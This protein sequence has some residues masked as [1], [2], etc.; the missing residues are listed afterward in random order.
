MVANESRCIEMDN[1]NSI[2]QNV[3]NSFNIPEWIWKPI[4]LT[5]SSGNPNNKYVT[6]KEYSVGLFQ[7]NRIAHPEYT[8][9]ELL[10]PKVN[11][12]IAAKDFIIPALNS[13]GFDY[14]SNPDWKTA[15]SIYSGLKDPTKTSD[16]KGSDYIKSGGI[17]PDWKIE[18]TRTRFLNNF[19]NVVSSLSLNST[20]N[21]TGDISGDDI[22]IVP[23]D[24]VDSYGNKTTDTDE[25][26]IPE[27]G[28]WQKALKTIVIIVLVVV[29]F[30]AVFL[31]LKET[32]TGKSLFRG[33]AAIATGGVSEI[34]GGEK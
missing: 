27:L 24:K 3:M 11:A 18:N 7:I 13:I 23:A 33:T 31:I 17:R 2:V 34:M 6:A 9:Q 4:M 15:A 10:D 21:I 28:F 12:T 22:K 5:E 29:G 8:E 14:S 19:N 16:I 25:T 32:E 30:I 26:G 1:I 20:G